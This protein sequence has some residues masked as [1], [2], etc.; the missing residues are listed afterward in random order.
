MGITIDKCRTCKYAFTTGK[1]RWYCK[2]SLADKD[3]CR[4][5]KIAIQLLKQEQKTN[6]LDKIRA[7]IKQT[8]DEEQKHDEKWAMGLRYAVKIIDKHKAERQEPCE[9]AISRS[10]IKQKLQ[11][12][13]DFYIKAYGGFSNLPQNDKSRVDE[14]TNCIAMVVNEPPVTP[15]HR[16]GYW[17]DEFGGCECSECGGLEAG[18]YDYCPNCGCRMTESQESE[19]QA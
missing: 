3:D 7:E 6:T 19:E 8:A 13:H 18:Y 14:I 17:I 5:Y 2:K 11:D 10:S 16:T 15:K 1:D 4:E 12:H 9:D